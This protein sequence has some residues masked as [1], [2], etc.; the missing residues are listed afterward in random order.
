[1]PTILIAEDHTI[2]RFGTILILKEVFADAVIQEA[3]NFDRVLQLLDSLPFDLIMLDINIP[4]GDDLKMIDLIKLKQP[5]IKI[6]VFSGYDEHI[7]AIPY[8]RAGAHGYITKHSAEADIKLALKTV[9]SNKLY[10]SPA[11]KEEL[12]MEMMQGK[13]GKEN[14]LKN[15]SSR[16]TE[17]MKLLIK[18][19]SVVRISEILHLQLSTVSTY[20]A[21]IF[22][23]LK[24]SNVIDLAEKN[25]LYNSSTEAG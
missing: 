2:V 25:K 17:V 18:G 20:K 9:M 21:R 23:K 16:E 3:G 19:V 13:S 8:L 15:L 11:I 6:L 24:V 1:M 14:P 22:D 10:T 4:G 12:V 5:H 7:F